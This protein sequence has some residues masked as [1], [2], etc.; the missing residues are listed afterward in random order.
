MLDITMLER[1]ALD[2]VEVR[3]REATIETLR[4]QTARAAGSALPSMRWTAGA[5]LGRV[6]S[7]RW[8]SNWLRT[9][10]APCCHDG[11]APCCHGGCLATTDGAP[12]GA[13][14][15]GAAAS[16]AA[17]SGAAPSGAA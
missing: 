10:A 13:A 17:A 1:S 2:R 9:T 12:A 8:S 7:G 11:D 5:W 6:A 3:R 4:R 14:P 15:S 16:G